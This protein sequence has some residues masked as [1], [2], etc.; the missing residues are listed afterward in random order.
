MFKTDFQDGRNGRHL[1]FPFCTNLAIFDLTVTSGLQMNVSN[2]LAFRLR[3]RI[4]KYFF[5][6]SVRGSHLGFL[7]GTIKIFLSTR[8]P[9]TYYQVLSQ[10]AIPFRRR[11]QNIFSRRGWQCFMSIG[12]SIQEKFKIDF[13]EV[14]TLDFGSEQF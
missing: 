5:Q 13:Q 2:Q 4:T 6:D 11:V 1:G 12:I 9:I 10:V 14:A 3:R 8:Y 7:T